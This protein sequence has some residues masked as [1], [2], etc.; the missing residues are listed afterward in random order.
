MLI[1]LYGKDAYR[2]HGKLQELI[3]TYKNKHELADLAFFDFA[4]E[5]TYA[6]ARHFVDSGSL[7]TDKKLAVFKNIIP[8]PEEGELHSLISDND[9]T[10]DANTIII[11]TSEKDSVSKK[12]AFLCEEPVV[13]QKFEHLTGGMPRQSG[14]QSLRT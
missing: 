5:G 12:W 3:D 9:L 7:F 10:K 6:H 8:S 2:R 14:G 11:A 1:F 13:H 4:E